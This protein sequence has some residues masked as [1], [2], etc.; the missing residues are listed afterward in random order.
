MKPTNELSD[1]ISQSDASASGSWREKKK[2]SLPLFP[3][4]EEQAR[5]L[6]RATISVSFLYA[7]CRQMYSGDK[8][9]T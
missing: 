9:A 3:A 8:R 1:V 7:Y 6:D 5:D 2:K 4:R